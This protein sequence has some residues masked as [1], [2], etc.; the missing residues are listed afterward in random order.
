MDHVVAAYADADGVAMTA[1]RM[2]ANG[3]TIEVDLAEVLTAIDPS[4][5]Y[6]GYDPEVDEDRFVSSSLQ[7]EIVHAASLE[8][9]KQ[10]RKG[11]EA[12]V[13]AEVRTAVAGQ[14]GE[15]VSETLIAP[16]QKTTEWGSPVGEAKPLAQLISEQAQDALRKP[17]LRDG[18]N[19]G[20]QLTMV[21][22]IIANEIEKAFKVE[23]QGHVKQAQQAA[24]AA[25]K[26]SAAEVI[27]ESI[28]RARRGLS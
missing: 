18:Y 15:I 8:L 23:L 22:R 1:T 11:I 14:V 4:G 13:L 26:A 19:R 5:R 25:V 9:V 3:I 24:V 6:L 16:V 21:Q 20:N 7:Q 17:E 12:A 27:G 2:T 10:A 28:D